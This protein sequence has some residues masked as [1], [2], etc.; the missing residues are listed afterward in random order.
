MEKIYLV[1]PSM[2]HEKSYIDM[3]VE[4][5]EAKEH[6]YPGVIRRKGTDYNNWLEI[7]ESYKKSETC[8]SRFVPSHNFFL[9]NKYG[10]VLGAISIRHYLNEELLLLSGHIGYGIRPSERRKG[11]AT[12]MLEM[13]LEKCRDM[14]IHEVLITCDKDNL[15][16]ARTIIANNG[17]LEN[18]IIED[19]GNIVQRYWIAL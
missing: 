19:D 16:S 5:E 3:M 4:W 1:A 14:G 18:E 10:K 11:Y 6:I 8:P 13:A 17:V 2:E 9:V 7:L 15:P 12:E